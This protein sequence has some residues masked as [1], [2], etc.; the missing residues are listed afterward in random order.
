MVIQLSLE[1]ILG[2]SS[3]SLENDGLTSYDF[4][5]ILGPWG[6]SDPSPDCIKAQFKEGIPFLL[7][8]TKEFY[9]HGNQMKRKSLK[10]RNQFRK[11][12]MKLRYAFG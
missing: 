9:G 8:V 11:L 4:N 10:I 6:P 5:S 2:N 12:H 3:L 7:R 1:G